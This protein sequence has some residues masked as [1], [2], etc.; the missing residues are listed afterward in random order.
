VDWSETNGYQPV[1]QQFQNFFPPKKWVFSKILV[2]VPE[3]CP[4]SFLV[5]ELDPILNPI[6]ISSSKIRP[7]SGLVWFGLVSGSQPSGLLYFIG[8]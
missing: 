3:P 5:P 1:N 2:P 6:S 4:G 7:S 8:P